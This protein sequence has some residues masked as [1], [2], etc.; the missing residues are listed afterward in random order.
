MSDMKEMLKN[1]HS[2]KPAINK[3]ISSMLRKELNSLETQQERL[4]EFLEQGIYT[5]EVFVKRNNILS[6]RRNEL[7]EAFEENWNETHQEHHE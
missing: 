6:Q 7:L 4:Y 2:E 1:N 5:S 3:N